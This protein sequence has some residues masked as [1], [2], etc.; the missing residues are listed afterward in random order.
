LLLFAGSC[1]LLWLALIAGSAGARS[2]VV[3]CPMLLFLGKKLVF[4]FFAMMLFS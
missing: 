3:P 2:F 1:G 4:T